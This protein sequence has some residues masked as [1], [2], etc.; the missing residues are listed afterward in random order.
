[1]FEL[2][3]M[4][5]SASAARGGLGLKSII[6]G[7][8]IAG[9][10]LGATAG[11]VAASVKSMI[12]VDAYSGRVYRAYNADAHH[13]P[14]SLAKLMTLYLT[15]E[16]IEKGKLRWNQRVRISHHAATRMPSKVYLKPGQRVRIRDL[17]YAAAVKSANDAA[18][19]LGEA[20]AGSEFRFAQLMTRRAHQLGMKNT[21]FG[22]ASGLPARG[23]HTTARDMARLA[24][25][26]ILYYTKYY[27]I[28][29]TRYF[30]FGRRTYANTNRL[31]HRGK[32]DGMKTGY[33]HRARFNLV[34]SVRHGKKRIITVVLGAS[35]SRT[36]YRKTRWLIAKAFH[37]RP[38]TNQYAAIHKPST[39][40][41]RNTAQ[42]AA[43]P[44]F[45]P[46]DKFDST[47]PEKTEP[48]SVV[49]ADADTAGKHKVDLSIMG[50]RANAEER[51]P[52][53]NTGKAVR[54]VAVN[55]RPLNRQTKPKTKAKVV[56]KAEKPAPKKTRTRTALQTV[57]PTLRKRPAKV[58]VT[59]TAY[60]V[61]VGAHPQYA[62]AQ[63]SAQRA[64]RALPSKLRHGVK[65]AVM[66]PQN[67]DGRF[68]RA[69]IVG[70]TKANADAACRY[71]KKKSLR[72]LAVRTSRRIQVA[73]ATPATR[74]TV[75]DV[76]A[77]RRAATTG[78][79]VV[80]V[81]AV[82]RYTNARRLARKARRSL[83]RALSR[84]A[85]A[86]ILKPGS[87]KGRLY[88][89][90]LSGLSQ[91]EAQKACRI[92]KRRSV[93]CMPMRVRTDRTQAAAVKRGHYA[94]Q[95]GAVTRRAKARRLIR[96]ARRTLPRR[97]ARQARARVLSPGSYDGRFYRA[98]LTGLSR[99]EATRACK[100]LRRKS[101]LN[102]LP[103]RDGDA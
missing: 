43:A 74:Q 48:K 13:P 34:T 80:Q 101:S 73:S 4:R 46:E 85:K 29:S 15:F 98:R 11:P 2:A 53:A 95:V 16:A 19:A 38:R 49:V 92:L 5:G 96:K 69:R 33:T 61:Q 45:R 66:R 23:Q 65:V 76:H 82:T 40:V 31:L 88:R 71:L 56:A 51:K 42:V 44:R 91:T 58:I 54:K 78:G 36:R 63:R 62:L 26:I 59:R 84:H 67:Y 64:F 32:V 57:R 79:Y 68:Y 90:R 97:I 47:E 83:P 7:A 6:A 70:L 72:C 77:A 28:F 1:V 75:S 3:G 21:H 9:A 52:G 50:S 93:R 55:V 35:S 14:A 87:Y 25:A 10:A 41:E 100:I 8:F 60:A 102:C 39:V 12:V 94:V 30:R 89:V 20:I 17:V 22:T 86:R 99:M 81:G 37:S 24:R 27:H 18:T 103:Y